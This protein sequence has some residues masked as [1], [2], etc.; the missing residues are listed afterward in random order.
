MLPTACLLIHCSGTCLHYVCEAASASAY[1][2]TYIA[3]GGKECGSLKGIRP[4]AV[5]EVTS[6]H[7]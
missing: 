1:A 3:M 6:C 4:A 5:Y 7:V 2:A